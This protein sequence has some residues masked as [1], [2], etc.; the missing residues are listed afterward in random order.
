MLKDLECVCAGPKGFAVNSL[1][2][3]AQS[4]LC[5]GSFNDI[6]AETELA[7]SVSAKRA[8]E[9][10]TKGTARRKLCDNKVC[11]KGNKSGSRRVH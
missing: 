10:G 2:C 8:L 11:L 1:N 4:A 3:Y 5:W 9:A 7:S 6:K